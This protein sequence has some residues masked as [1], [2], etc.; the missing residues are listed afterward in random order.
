MVQFLQFLLITVQMFCITPPTCIH[1]LMCQFGSQSKN[2]FDF[3][4]QHLYSEL[5]CL[6]FYFQILLLFYSFILQDDIEGD[7]SLTMLRTIVCFYIFSF[8]EVIEIRPNVFFFTVKVFVSFFIIHL[9]YQYTI[10]FSLQ[11]R[12][13]VCLIQNTSCYFLRKRT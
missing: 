6:F 1:S 3:G 8:Q 10:Y 7:N 2:L 5:I 13:K 4:T 11:T 12:N 9:S